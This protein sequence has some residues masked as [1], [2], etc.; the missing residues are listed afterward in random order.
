LL[1]LVSN[2]LDACSRPGARI[3]DVDAAASQARAERFVGRDADAVARQPDAE[4][5]AGFKSPGDI[6]VVWAHAE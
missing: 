1:N 4:I 5:I 6:F 3:E 2:L